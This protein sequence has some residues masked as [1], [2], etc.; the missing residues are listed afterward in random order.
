MIYSKCQNLLL[1]IHQ[2]V[3]FVKLDQLESGYARQKFGKILTTPHI[4][5]YTFS[6]HRIINHCI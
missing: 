2:F 4:I 5:L 1:N 3:R 6:N